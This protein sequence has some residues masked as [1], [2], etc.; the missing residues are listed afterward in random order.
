MRRKNKKNYNRLLVIL[1]VFGL[2]IGFAYLSTELGVNGS[3][4]LGRQYLK[5][6][7]TDSEVIQSTATVSSQ[8]TSDD[9][10]TLTYTANFSNVGDRV[11]FLIMAENQGTLDA[12][13]NN[14]QLTSYNSSGNEVSSD[15][16]DLN[17]YYTDYAEAQPTNILR[18]GEAVRYVVEI[19]LNSTP[20]DTISSTSFVMTFNSANTNA[21][22]RPKGTS[23]TCT[24]NNLYFY[25][26]SSS[27]G[28]PSGSSSGYSAGAS[29]ICK[30]AKTLHTEECTIN[31]TDDIGYSRGYCMG[32]GYYSTA[33]PGTYGY[34]VSQDKY[35]DTSTV[36]YGSCGSIGELNFG[37][38]FT[39]DVNGDGT[40]D[41]VN[42]RFYF[43]SNTYIRNIY[44]DQNNMSMESLL[45][46]S[47]FSSQYATLIYSDNFY[48]GSQVT[49]KNT[50]GNLRNY[51]IGYSSNYE[52]TT[53]VQHLPTTTTWSY[54][55]NDISFYNNSFMIG[56]IRDIIDSNNNILYNRTQ[57]YLNN[58]ISARI[59]TLQELQ[60]GI[61]DGVDITQEG[62]LDDYPFLFEN[63]AYTYPASIV[64]NDRTARIM[65]ETF[66]STSSSYIYYI[67]AD[68]RNINTYFENDGMLARPVIE[69]PISDIAY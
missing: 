37:D 18:R 29:K 43:V 49:V 19:E 60:H 53:L 46:E 35:K 16:F 39:C 11:T 33:S 10:A 9:N 51:T 34:G 64:G 28:E 6:V 27:L 17:V 26:S 54:N 32:S 62:S 13:I 47:G 61:G 69:V 3:A 12:M 21:T 52:P 2:V 67:G 38:A 66:S 45:G 22:E 56:R 24:I 42:E 1:L 4:L 7:F 55:N 14:F 59:L 31:N 5:V 57:L 40:Y 68:Y 8:E 48:Q 50:S 36:K 25:N 44:D 23:T 41:E 65:L 20:S 30:R 58:N 15:C 63:S